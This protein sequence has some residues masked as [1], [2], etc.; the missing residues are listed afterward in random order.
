MMM[1]NHLQKNSGLCGQLK[2]PLTVKTTEFIAKY[3]FWRAMN[4][5]I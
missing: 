5:K 1:P 4:T 3:R 2:T